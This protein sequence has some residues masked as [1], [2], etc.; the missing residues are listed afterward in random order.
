MLFLTTKTIE[1]AYYK[2]SNLVVSNP[3]ILQ[4]FFILKACGY[5][6]NEY[7]STSEIGQKGYGPAWNLCGLFSVDEKIP[8]KYDFISPFYMKEWGSQAP[9]EPLKKWVSGRI[10]NNVIGGATTWR[11]L[12][13]DDQ[14]NG[15]FKFT[16]N[17]LKELKELTLKSNK[18]DALAFAVWFSRFVSFPRAVTSR[19]LIIST[20]KRL[21]ISEKEF[22]SL[23]HL[24]SEI[25]LAFDSKLHNSKNVRELIGI[26]KGQLVSWLEAE[27]VESSKSQKSNM[28]LEEVMLENSKAVPLSKISILLNTNKQIILAGPPGT[29]K[30]HNANLLAENFDNDKVLKI[31][32]HPKY[33]YQDFIGGYV[34]EGK[35]VSYEKGVFRKF[36]DKAIEE[37]D[38][39]FLIIIDEIN[40]ANVGQV[41]GETIQCLDRNYITSIKEGKVEVDFCIPTNLFIVGTMNTADRSIGNIDFAIKRRFVTVYTP[42]EPEKLIDLCVTEFG[43]SCSDL[44][45]KIN[46][47]LCNILKNKELVVGHA[48]FLQEHVHGE[49]VYRWNAEQFELFF[50][51][52]LLPIIVDYTRGNETQLKQILGDKLPSL[53]SGDDLTTALMEYLAND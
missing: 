13:D 6:S 14:K 42:P 50:N 53:L 7:K 16:Y 34:V 29:S 35:D 27:K 22:Q 25:Q 33:S 3:S 49:G 32:F 52:K 41:F 45:S 39:D 5:D 31:Q 21:N 51:F 30:S 8:P 9:S 38:S 37:N 4:I 18:I 1:C 11:L 48:V 12:V 43:I 47:R 19:E 40:R 24:S 20:R 28:E 46:V 44:L 26:P 23:F 15:R 2:L 17:Y 10:K 36:V